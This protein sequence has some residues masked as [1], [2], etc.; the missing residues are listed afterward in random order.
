[1]DTTVKAAMLKSSQT[2]IASPVPDPSL[3]PPRTQTLRKAHSIESLGSPRAPALFSDHEHL[4]NLHT[5]GVS[6]SQVSAHH[7]PYGG[8]GT[9]RKGSAHGRGLSFDAPRLFSKS[10]VNLPASTSTLDLLGG[11]SKDRTV[12]AK[13]ITPPKFFSILSSTSSTELDIEDVKKLRLLLRNE[14]ASWSQEFLKLGGYS[15]L[16]TRLNEI[17]EVE[18]RY[19]NMILN[20]SALTQIILQGRATR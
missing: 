2:M 9:P 19:V 12:P 16:L 18:W 17:L 6:V 5:A 3:T 10:Q 11:K 1:M 4:E 7:S 8:S 13:N 15:A 14:S 20:L